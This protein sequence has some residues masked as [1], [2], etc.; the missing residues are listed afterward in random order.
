ME[1]TVDIAAQ[2]SYLEEDKKFK[3]AV[4]DEVTDDVD[5]TTAC[6]R[7]VESLSAINEFARNLVAEPTKSARATIEAAHRRYA[8]VCSEKLLGLT[9]TALDNGHET[10]FVPLLL[11]WDDVRLELQKRNSQLINLRK[12]YVTGRAMSDRA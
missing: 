6:R 4:L 2:R 7:Y 9:A 5:L 8:E 1:F 11:D 3:K 12:R 10:A